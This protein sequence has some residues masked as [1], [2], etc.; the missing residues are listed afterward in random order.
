MRP[1]LR[2]P[3]LLCICACTSAV[4]V[5]DHLTPEGKVLSSVTR[6]DAGKQGEAVIFHHNGNEA[7]RGTYAH[8]LKE[9]TWHEWSTD[10]RPTALL[11][12]HR[13]RLHGHCRWMAPDG[14][15]L[16][17]ERFV[18]G[19]LD[20]HVRRYFP[21]GRLRQE[22]TY[23]LGKAEGPYWRHMDAHE[24]TSAGPII[25]G[26]YQDGLSHGLWRGYT[27]DGRMTSEGGFV[28]GRRVGI[29]RHWDRSGRQVREDEFDAEGRLVTSNTPTD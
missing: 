23:R 29:W 5:N 9:G 2:L 26:H 24:D 11:N 8:E 19:L 25:T 16:S 22:L 17:D 27:G 21:D 4:Q 6:A 12:Y 15:V 13:G 28:R 7:K 20:G 14:Q 1:L 3:I 18:D 10:G